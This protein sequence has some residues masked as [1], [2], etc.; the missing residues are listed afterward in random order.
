MAPRHMRVGVDADGILF[1]LVEPWLN[2]YNNEF[3]DDRKVEHVRHF[4]LHRS[5][6]PDGGPLDG[7]RKER[8]YA[9]LQTPGLFRGLTPLPGAQKALRH[10][11]QLAEV[12]IVSKP[13][14]GLCAAEKIDSFREYFPFV[15]GVVLTGEKHIVDVHVLVDDHPENARKF[16]DHYIH[17]ARYAMGIQWPWN[18]SSDH[19]DAFDVLGQC[20]RKPAE[21]WDQLV[22]AIEKVGEDYR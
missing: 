16:R 21:A 19:R 22:D 14:G 17:R 12:Y 5:L 20:W 18:D 7:V 6:G 1:D 8:L 4:D 15:D 3:G 10:L 11:K 9:M 13:C 2:I